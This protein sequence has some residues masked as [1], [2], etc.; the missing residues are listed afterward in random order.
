[1]LSRLFIVLKWML[2]S[3]VFFLLLNLLIPSVIASM[4]ST[5]ITVGAFFHPDNE[6]ECLKLT[7]PQ[8]WVM[9]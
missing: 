1:M 5:V 4:L 3:G 6:I 8:L 7:R 9:S 2:F